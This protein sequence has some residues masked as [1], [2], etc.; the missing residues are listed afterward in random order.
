MMDVQAIIIVHIGDVA[1]ET[2]IPVKASGA[3]DDSIFRVL[4]QTNESGY[5]LDGPYHVVRD[6]KI[7][8][9]MPAKSALVLLSHEEDYLTTDPLSPED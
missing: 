7:F 6:G 5:R 1:V 9:E 2:S 3:K 4:M 8:V